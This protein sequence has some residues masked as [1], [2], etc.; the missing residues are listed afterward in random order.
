MARAGRS[1][2]EGRIYHVYN[3]VGGGRRRLL[4]KSWQPSSGNREAE[5]VIGIGGGRRMRTSRLLPRPLIK[6]PARSLDW[7]N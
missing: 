2:E 3:R 6:P 1:F 5:S 7:G 4:T